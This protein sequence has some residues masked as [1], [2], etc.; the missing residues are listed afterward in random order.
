MGFKLKAISTII[1][2]FFILVSPATALE[3]SKFFPALLIIS[4]VGL[5]FG[6]VYLETQANEAY[7]NYLHTALQADMKKYTD[8]Y[9]SKH[10][11]SI[12]AS[13][14]GAGFW[15]LAV[16]I[17]IYRQLHSVSV[18]ESGGNAKLM[19]GGEKLPFPSVYAR[20][21]DALFVISR[22]F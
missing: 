1:I 12:I 8:D 9:D 16:F 20:N 17:F 10:T 13:G 2:I 22:R 4:G 7:D 15:G 6:S 14:V 19:L 3:K 11:Q 18:E 21:G 5:K